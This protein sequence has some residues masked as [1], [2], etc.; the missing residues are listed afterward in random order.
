MR[1]DTLAGLGPAGRSVVRGGPTLG[2]STAGAV[3]APGAAGEVA[4]GAALEVREFV[5][6]FSVIPPTLTGV[7]GLVSDGLG[8]FV[9]TSGSA[10]V[11]KLFK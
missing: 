7:W 1:L 3:A 11:S 10:I 4:P 5:R 2:V 9:S 6:F 8:P